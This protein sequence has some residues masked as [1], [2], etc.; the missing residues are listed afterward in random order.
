[1][2]SATGERD[3]LR[4]KSSAAASINGKL[5]DPKGRTAKQ[6]VKKFVA[7]SVLDDQIN[8]LQFLSSGHEGKPFQCPLKG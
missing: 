2:S 3:L 4:C 1:M 8:L 5:D 7:E 6:Y